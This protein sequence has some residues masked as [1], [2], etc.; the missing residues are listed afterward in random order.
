MT[1]ISRPSTVLA[2]A[3]IMLL[4]VL[5][6]TG[7]RVENIERSSPLVLASI[8]ITPAAPSMAPGTTMQLQAI[9]VYSNNAR[10]DL[11]AFV[12][13]DSSDTGVATV[14]STGLASSGNV[15]SSTITATFS[16]IT[17]STVL[18][19]SPLVSIAIT[20]ADQSIAPETTL[21]LAAIGTLLDGETQNLTTFATWD[22]SDTSI[23]TVGDTQGTKGLAE[24]LT[25]GT[26]TVT[27]SF[28]TISGSTS[29]TSSTVTTLAVTPA[30]ATI[31]GG[32]TKQFTAT[33]TLADGATQNLTAF[34]TWSSSDPGVATISGTGLASA[35]AQGSTTITASF[36]TISETATLTV[37][38]PALVLISVTPATATIAKGATQQ[39]AAL[40]TFSDG[41]TQDLTSQPKIVWTSSDT[42]VATINTTGLASSIGTGTATITAKFSGITSNPATL[43]VTAPA[44]VSIAVTPTSASVQSGFSQQFVAT[45]IFS[46]GTTQNLT[47]KATWNSSNPFVATISNLPGF[48]GQANAF[49]AGTTNIT[50]TSSGITSNTAVLTV[51]F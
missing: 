4:L 18:K 6:T 35:V 29:L 34:V 46:D 39:F 25:P 37:T 49:T 3:Y 26:V 40:G 15:G 1:H 30:T 31:A 27:A 14:S 22:S 5:V 17:G 38:A 13:W 44:L 16:G 24:A 41:S 48:Q 51:P 50:A 11:T 23:V 20:P 45:G 33:G 8:T 43:T 42:G 9:G 36:A 7:C 32:T 2:Y 12:T 47:T 21:Q 19:T 28:G 10:Q